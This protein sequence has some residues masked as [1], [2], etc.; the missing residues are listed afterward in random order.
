MCVVQGQGKRWQAGRQA[1]E[2]VVTVMEV[3][4]GSKASR[5]NKEAGRLGERQAGSRHDCV[6]VVLPVIGQCGSNAIPCGQ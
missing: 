1:G 2:N 4:L 6:Y 5:E 3:A